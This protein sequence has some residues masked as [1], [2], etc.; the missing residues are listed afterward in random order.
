MF[1]KWAL[2][3]Y[4]SP[5]CVPADQKTSPGQVEGL[6][7]FSPSLTLTALHWENVRCNGSM[8][9][10]LSLGAWVE[11]CFHRC[12][13]TVNYYSCSNQSSINSI[14]VIHSNFPNHL[15]LTELE[16]SVELESSPAVL[17][18]RTTSHFYRG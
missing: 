8:D 6:S 12:Y 15:F 4:L 5:W 14:T 18:V 11:Q 13:Q 17:E 7:V 10:W 1:W 9:G 2:Q 16:R 3:E